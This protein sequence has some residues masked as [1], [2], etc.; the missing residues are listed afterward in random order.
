MSN[1]VAMCVS[2]WV[3]LED[4]RFSGD[5]LPDE[6]LRERYFTLCERGNASQ[7]KAFIDDLWRAADDMGLEELADW[8]TEMNDPT[9][10][11]ARYWTHDGIEYLDAAHTLPRSEM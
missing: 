7:A 8:F 4:G 9:T 11:T 2:C 1:L 10:I 6:G 3:L 5:V